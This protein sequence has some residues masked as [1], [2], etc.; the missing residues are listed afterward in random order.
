MMEK[1]R[2]NKSYMM[3]AHCTVPRGNC[4]PHFEDFRLQTRHFETPCFQYFELQRLDL[5]DF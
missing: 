4:Y 2:E 5:T 1:K 3:Y